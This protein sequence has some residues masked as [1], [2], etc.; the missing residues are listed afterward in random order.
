MK[1]EQAKRLFL[2]FLDF[3]PHFQYNNSI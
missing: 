1:E 2:F 3:G